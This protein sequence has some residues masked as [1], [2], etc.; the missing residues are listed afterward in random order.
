MTNFH[1]RWMEIRIR[2]DG[3]IR[4]NF[5]L[6]SSPAFQVVV[7]CPKPASESQLFVQCSSLVSYFRLSV[8]HSQFGKLSSFQCIKFI[9]HESGSSWHKDDF[10]LLKNTRYVLSLHYYFDTGY[11]IIWN[12]NLHCHRSQQAHFRNPLLSTQTLHVLTL[13]GARLT[14]TVGSD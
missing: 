13:K 1:C 6:S 4:A 2:H 7:C 12:L 5:S 3:A 14:V 11:R 8:R 9:F 10:E